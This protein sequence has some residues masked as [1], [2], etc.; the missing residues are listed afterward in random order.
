MSIGT[1]VVDL[2]ARTGSFETDLERAAKVAK[3]RAEEIDKTLKIKSIA[4]GNAVGDA[5]SEGIRRAMAIIPDLINGLDALN[6]VK[7]ATGASIANISALEDVALRTGTTL[8]N[9]SGILVKF[10]GVLKEA[11][12]KNEVS[13]VLKAIGLDAAELRKLDPAEA[14]RQTAVALSG[15]ADNGSKARDIQILFGKSIKDAAPFLN[16]LAEKSE[17][18]GKVSDES[19]GR[20]EAFN[21]QIAA[22]E[23]NSLDAK[24]ALLDNLLPAINAVLSALNKGGVMAAIDEFGE[25]TLGWTSNAMNK[26]I[27]NAQSDLERA[28]AGRAQE[29]AFTGGTSASDAAIAAAQQRV[30]DAEKA[31]MKFRDRDAGASAFVPQ[32]DKPTLPEPKKPQGGG[33]KDNSAAQEAKAQLAQDLEDMKKNTALLTGAFDND[34]KILQAKRSASLISDAEYF[35]KRRDLIIA[36]GEIE[37]AGL[38]ASIDRLKK[39]QATLTGK[40]AIDNQRKLN[41]AE[42]E[43][44]KSRAE[45]ATQ[46]KVLNI[47][48]EASTKKLATAMEDARAAAQ[49]FL[50]VTNRS[51]A[52]ELAGMGQG[53]KQRDYS[54]A[55]SQIEQ[56][57]EQKRQ[58]LERD[59]RNGKFAG[60]EDDYKRE[61]DLINEFQ[62]KS[63]DSYRDYYGE[64]EARQKAFNL[65]ASEG[66]RNYA[67]EASNVFKQTEDAVK[68]AFSGMEDA[69]VNFVKTGKLDFK[70]LVDS[71]ISDV[72]RIVIKSQITGPLAG[73]LSQALN[74][75]GAGK[76][77]GDAD[78]LSQIGLS[79][80][81]GL[82]ITGGTGSNFFTG[83]GSSIGKFFSGLGFADGG[84]PP[85]GVASMVGERG[86]E[87]FVPNTAG[88]IIP[89]HLL[90]GMGGGDTY[91]Y[92]F[93]VGDVATVGMLKQALAASQAQT[94]A[95]AT[96]SQRYRGSLG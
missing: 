35:Q 6:D 38:Q 24:R 58:D 53:T 95:A 41:D 69:L 39:E 26:G 48:A 90:G 37:D 91:N 8:E 47:D 28:Q 34:E 9:V 36:T 46:L 88:K 86:P 73:L 14:L 25:R 72:A 78:Y 63:I 82:S 54:A 66:A 45:T 10:N 30:R 11:D 96:R 51:R 42:A 49:S 89:N 19:A 87:L 70:S 23:K 55:I 22:F 74:L 20:A 75:G 44:R 62:K 65:G 4:I 52:L 43:L 33:K 93:T 77:S 94:A 80:A 71:I 29:L 67:D 84:S 83:I 81:S 59:R 5:I 12:G 13:Q 76:V 17:L 16:D 56:T 50:D 64:L 18:V 1:I 68:N 40:D 57:Y 7:D 27:K 21:K 92:D 79:G 85:V 60:R 31:F 61:L 15:F 32:P 2:M 3:K